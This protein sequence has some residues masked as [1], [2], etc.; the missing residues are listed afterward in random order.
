MLIKK[1]SYGL[2]P[3]VDVTDIDKKFRFRVYDAE[4]TS[5]L[6]DLAVENGACMSTKHHDYSLLP[7]H[8]AV[9]NLLEKTSK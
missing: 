6:D 2:H 9:S 8:I 4:V 5:E 1:L 7:R 3:V